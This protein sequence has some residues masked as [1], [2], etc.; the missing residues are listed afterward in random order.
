VAA[1]LFGWHAVRDVFSIVYLPPAVRS[2]SENWNAFIFGA[3]D[4]ASSITTDKIPGFLWPQA[5]SARIFGFHA[6]SIALPVVIEGLITVLVLYRVVR[7][8]AGP[9]A[10][11]LAAAT[12]AVTPIIAAMFWRSVADAPLIMC[13]VLA[14]DAWQRAVDKGRLRS[15]LLAGVWVGLGF[16]AKMLMAWVILPALAIAYIACAPNPMRRR[17]AQVGL[18]GLVTIGVSLF[19]VLLVELTP[20]AHRPYIDGSTNNSAVAMVFGYNGLER[21]GIHL[22]GALQASTSGSSGPPRSDMAGLTPGDRRPGTG[23]PAQ[24]RGVSAGWDRLL[25]PG[26]ASQ[27]GWQ[28][29]LALVAL[30]LGLLWRWRDRQLRSGLLMWGLWLV[31]LGA[32]YSAGSSMH[33]TYTALLAPPLAALS[34]AGG[35]LLWR[36]YRAGGPRAWAL[37]SAI[38]ATVA[39]TTYLS[40]QYSSFMPWLAP[41]VLAAGIIGTGLLVV[42]LLG[43]HLPYRLLRAGLA[44]AIMA[45]LATPLGWAISELDPDYLELSGPVA[46]PAGKQGALVS[47]MAAAPMLQG[48]S[49]TD[50]LNPSQQSLLDYLHAHSSGEKYLFATS[51]WMTATPY[52]LSTGVPVLTLGGFSGAVPFPTLDQFRNLVSTGQLRYVLLTQR[53]GAGDVSSLFGAA[54]QSSATAIRTWVSQSCT[55][56]PASDYGGTEPS[57]AGQTPADRRSAAAMAQTAGQLFDC[58][59]AP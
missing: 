7:R 31:I 57:W 43:R 28:Y 55:A 53:G 36:E 8:W 42:P 25:A 4:P 40:L 49:V 45:V 30:L 17:L 19:W 39:W 47:Q 46:G 1:V 51:S 3:F 33:A 13:L 20:A 21:F 18:A 37:P 6:W 12:F 22:D 15:L 2:M 29:P 24:A 10:G 9:V 54:R 52:I 50:K 58:Q 34:A 23:N 11:L 26:L 32:V 5:L 56:I 27:A 14:A 38:A 16:H 41:T 35:V 48:L 44:T 59:P